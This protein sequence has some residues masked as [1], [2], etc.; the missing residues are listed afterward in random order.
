MDNSNNCSLREDKCC[1]AEEKE[2]EQATDEKSSSSSQLGVER[3][4]GTTNPP[5]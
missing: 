4:S 2:R 1:D 5:R 3:S